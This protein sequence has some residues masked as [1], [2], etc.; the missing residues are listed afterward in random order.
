M[1]E[2]FSERR[3]AL[4]A[5][6]DGAK[7]DCLLVTHPA[8]I[9]YL[10][11][12]TGEAG[13]VVL[14]EGQCHLVTDGRFKVQA[15]EETSGVRIVLQKGSLFS[16]VG[17]M[18]R[19]GGRQAVG[20]DADRLT[21]AQL[22]LLRKASGSH[23]HLKPAPPIAERLRSKK[24]PGEIAA[25]R[26]SA[27]LAGEVLEFAVRSLKPNVREREI[28][29]EIEYKMRR[30]GAS[31]PAFESIVA[32]G[33]R[34]ALPHARPTGKQL[35]KNELVVLDLGA[36]LGHYCSDITRT[37]YVGRAPRRIRHWYAAVCRV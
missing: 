21:V 3:R 14:S 17:E 35:R 23:C 31:G 36:I 25:M 5:E 13:A 34:S 24:D 18:L 26:K 2:L 1:R 22:K 15:R 6:L 29:A 37:V 12:F 16:S 19:A 33:R 4:R 7:L 9:Y 8:S 20:Y 11:G 10:T 30:G 27:I 32:F 28:A